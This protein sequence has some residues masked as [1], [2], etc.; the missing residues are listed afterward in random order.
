M[1][2]FLWCW[3]WIFLSSGRSSVEEWKVSNGFTLLVLGSVFILRVW[4][5][6][7]VGFGQLWGMDLAGW[8]PYVV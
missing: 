6:T 3:Q 2:P 5:L 1:L 7:M 4:V 8:F